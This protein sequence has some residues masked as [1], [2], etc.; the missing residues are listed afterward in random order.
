LPGG[1]PVLLNA[2]CPRALCTGAWRYRD[3]HGYT[4]AGSGTCIVDIRFNC[5]P[6]VTLHRLEVMPD[7]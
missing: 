4:S 3:L 1:F 6:E 7:G 2:R 5:P